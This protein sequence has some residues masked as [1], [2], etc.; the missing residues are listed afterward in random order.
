MPMLSRTTEMVEGPLA[1]HRRTPSHR[2]A[3]RGAGRLH[4]ESHGRRSIQ[5]PWSASDPAAHEACEPE[6]LASLLSGRQGSAPPVTPSGI[7]TLARTQCW[8]SSWARQS[9]LG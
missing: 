6:A 5:L 1:S 3:I 4:L 7:Q 2:H 8:P 9:C